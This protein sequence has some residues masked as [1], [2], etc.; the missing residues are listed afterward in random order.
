MFD[1]DVKMRECNK[2]RSHVLAA[3]IKLNCIPCP[4]CDFQGRWK[5][6]TEKH[7]VKVHNMKIPKAFSRFTFYSLKYDQ[8]S[9]DDEKELPFG[10]VCCEKKREEKQKRK[11]EEEI[12]EED[13]SSEAAKLPE[14]MSRKIV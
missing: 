1:C 4:Q 5:K 3:H 7:C 12:I 11:E 13:Q 9:K 6:N 14:N 2:M 8:S 10:V